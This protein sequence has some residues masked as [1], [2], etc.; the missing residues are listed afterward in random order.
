MTKDQKTDPLV[1]EQGVVEGTEPVIPTL[2][3]CK[4][5]GMEVVNL[6]EHRRST[7]RDRCIPAVAPDMV[8][9]MRERRS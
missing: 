7:G 2:K 4:V 6:V 5:C 8:A 9:L 3:T 1:A